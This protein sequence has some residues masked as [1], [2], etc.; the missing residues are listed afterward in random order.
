MEG[1]YSF[2]LSSRVISIDEFQAMKDSM[3]DRKDTLNDLDESDLGTDIDQED[4]LEGNMSDAGSEGF[5]FD[6][7]PDDLIEFDEDEGG[8]EEDGEEDEEEEEWGGIEE[9]AKKRKN[10]KDRAQGRKRQRTLPTFGTY[11]DYARMIEDGPEDS[12]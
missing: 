7:D 4:S 1:E 9:S 11:E 12:I 6:E 8:L 10:G 5:S 2:S 3:P